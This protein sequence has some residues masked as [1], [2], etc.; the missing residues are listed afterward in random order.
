MKKNIFK[1]ILLENKFEKD[2]YITLDLLDKEALQNLFQLLNELAQM[3]DESNV[4]IKSS[5]ELSFFNSDA[6]YKRLVFDKVYAFF[7]PYLDSILDNYEPLI[8]N[9]FNK[10]PGTGEVPLHQN[11]TF[12]DESKYT[13][14][15][16]WIPLC[17]VSRKNG[18]LEMSPGTHKNLSAYRSPSIPWVFSGLE[19]VIKKNYMKPLELKVGQIAILDDAILHYSGENKSDKDRGTIQ[20][21]MKPKEAK[22]IHYYCENIKHGELEVFEV[23]P[24]F[25]TTFDMRLKPSGVPVIE[26]ISFT[27]KPI[28]KENEFKRLVNVVK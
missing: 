10:K 5:Y 24:D 3:K 16:V 12:V 15:S 17:D 27:H 18:T 6:S 19:K 23:T 21:I 14:V 2:G 28:K 20:L 7:K 9:L 25:F 4:Q 11:W 22:A 26:R 8:I 1:N 13:S